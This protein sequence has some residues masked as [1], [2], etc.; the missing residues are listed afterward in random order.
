MLGVVILHL[1][2]ET[3]GIPNEYDLES[4]PISVVFRV[5]SEAIFIC[6]TNIFV[7]I[8]GYFGIRFKIKS[9]LNLLFQCAYFFFGICFLLI[10]ISKE[11]F[12]LDNIEKCLMLPYDTAWFVKSYLGLYVLAPVCNYFVTY[13]NKR[14]FITVLVSFYILQSVYGWIGNSTY[15]ISGGFSAY[16]FIGL[17][18]LGRYIYKYNPSYAQLKTSIN[19][20]IFFILTIGISTMIIIGI[21]Y[22][23]PGLISRAL[24]YSNPLVIAQAIFLLL[25]FLK[26]HISS[27]II[28]WIA[29]SCFAVFLGHFMIFKYVQYSALK[30]SQ[31]YQPGVTIILLGLLACSFFL[32]CILADKIRLIIWNNLTKNFKE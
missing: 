32:I 9:L 26:F 1:N 15:Y 16:S 29:S 8:S 30:I 25:I 4:R 5:F 11:L 22:Q 17:Y 6:A 12:S 28:N 21:N 2:F 27:S 3:F 23:I 31:L 19:V 20:F 18:L 10:L 24:A 7:L 14:E 13:C